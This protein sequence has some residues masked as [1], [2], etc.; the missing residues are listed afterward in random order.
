MIH[1]V[2]LEMLHEIVESRKDKVSGQDF[3]ADGHERICPVEEGRSQLSSMAVPK[4][5]GDEKDFQHQCLLPQNQVRTN[6]AVC[7][8]ASLLC[9][10]EALAT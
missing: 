9:H 7:L 2:G 8:H 10:L 1:K 4:P 5:H 3:Q 6:G